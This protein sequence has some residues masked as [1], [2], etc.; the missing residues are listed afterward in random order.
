MAA[1][2]R[3]RGSCKLAPLHYDY[4]YPANR[5]VWFALHDHQT[6]RHIPAALA[7]SPGCIGC[8]LRGQMAVVLGQFPH[9][10]TVG[11]QQDGRVVVVTSP[12][13]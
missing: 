2:Y 10:G 7:S 12:P 11:G 5:R 9:V 4:F 13:I 3:R 8:R 1:R 6:R